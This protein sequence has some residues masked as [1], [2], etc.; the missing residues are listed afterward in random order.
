[1][2]EQQTDIGFGLSCIDLLPDAIAKVFIKMAYSDVEEVQGEVVAHV[3]EPHVKMNTESVDVCPQCGKA[4]F[5]KQDG[6]TTCLLDLGGYGHS[7][8]N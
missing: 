8:C 1:L 7:K 3:E 5:V 2:L 6:C 4:R